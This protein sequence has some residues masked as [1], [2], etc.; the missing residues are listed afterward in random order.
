[1]RSLLRRFSPLSRLRYRKDTAIARNFSLDSSFHGWFEREAKDE[2]HRL[3]LASFLF[4]LYEAQ[5]TPDLVGYQQRN[6]H[7]AK[8]LERLDESNLTR[9]LDDCVNKDHIVE[10]ALFHVRRNEQ[11]LPLCAFLPRLHPF[12]F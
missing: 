6:N 9:F 12:S 11:M 3:Q 2:R 7:H 4:T 5:A 10:G 1:M 8:W